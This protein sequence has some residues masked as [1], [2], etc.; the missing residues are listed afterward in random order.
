LRA[1]QFITTGSLNKIFRL[2]QAARIE[3]EIE[4]LGRAR[5]DLA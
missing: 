4:G 5:L 1:G 2:S 3:A